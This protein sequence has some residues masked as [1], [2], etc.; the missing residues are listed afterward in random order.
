MCFL[1]PPRFPCDQAGLVQ[2]PNSWIPPESVGEGA[3]SLFGGGPESR[4]NVSCTGATPRLHRCKSGVAL[5]QETFSRLPGHPPKRLL[6]PSPTDSGGIQEF[7]HCNRP[8]GSQRF[9]LFS[10]FGLP[11]PAPFGLPLSRTPPA[12]NQYM[13]EKILGELIFARIHAGPV[14]A[15]ARIQ[16]NIFEEVF[17]EYFAKLLGEFTRCEYMPRLY[18]HPH[19]YRKILQANYLCIGFVPGCILP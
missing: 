15:L 4:E 7:G 8:A 19:E 17:P 1:S 2:C 6:A 18:L 9:P 12:Q 14:F 5:E 10:L 3:N 11:V 16:E 13:Q